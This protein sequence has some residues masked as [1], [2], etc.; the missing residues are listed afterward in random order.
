MQLCMSW[1]KVKIRPERAQLHAE[2]EVEFEISAGGTTC[3]ESPY[4]LYHDEDR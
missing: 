2:V 3:Q 4:V 1:G